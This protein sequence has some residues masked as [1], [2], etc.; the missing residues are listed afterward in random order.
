MCSQI[1]AVDLDRLVEA[2]LETEDRDA[3]GVF[4]NYGI[5]SVLALS[6]FLAYIYTAFSF[7]PRSPA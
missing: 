3:I 5:L 2:E 7:S 6:L 1:A 4:H